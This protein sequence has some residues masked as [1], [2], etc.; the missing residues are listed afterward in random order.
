MNPPSRAQKGN[1]TYASS[2]GKLR[3]RCP[4]CDADPG[5]KCVLWKVASGERMYVIRSMIKPHPE[6]GRP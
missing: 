4:I 1:R 3:Y 6:R 5:H 2:S